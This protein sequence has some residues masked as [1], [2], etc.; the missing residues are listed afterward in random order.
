MSDS[1]VL[2]AIARDALPIAIMSGAFFLIVVVGAVF[3]WRDAR[4]AQRRLEEDRRRMDREI[5]TA[6]RQRFL[7]RLHDNDTRRN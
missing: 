7:E 5:E 1:V 3:A 6:R 2:N 4:R